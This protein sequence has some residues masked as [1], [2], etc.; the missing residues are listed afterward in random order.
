[1][2]SSLRHP[3]PLFILFLFGIWNSRWP[4][5]LEIPKAGFSS[6][7]TSGSLHSSWFNYDLNHKWG[8]MGVSGFGWQWSFKRIPGIQYQRCLQSTVAHTDKVFVEWTN[9]WGKSL[10]LGLAHDHWRNTGR[11]W[12]IRC[13]S[14]LVSEW[15]LSG[16]LFQEQHLHSVVCI[17]LG[18]LQRLCRCTWL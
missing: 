6:Q 5:C 11:R 3:P 10:A 16:G 4:Q 2:T 14:L 17:L 7:V 15:P 12:Y 9:E 13:F 18:G 8:L 1:M